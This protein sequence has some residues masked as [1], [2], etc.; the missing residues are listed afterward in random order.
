[1]HKQDHRA[2]NTGT[3]AYKTSEDRREMA[4]SGSF[5]RVFHRLKQPVTGSCRSGS[6]KFSRKRTFTLTF[7]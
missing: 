4:L 3:P 2:N 1:M 5:S 7:K 6:L